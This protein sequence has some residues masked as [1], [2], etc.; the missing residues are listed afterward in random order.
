MNNPAIKHL[1]DLIEDCTNRLREAQNKVCEIHGE[2]SAYTNARNT[3][4]QHLAVNELLT[5]RDISANWKGVLKHISKLDV[6]SIDDI[7][8]FSDKNS[9][10]LQRGAIRSQVHLYNR[11]GILERVGTAQYR[12]TNS[13]K[14]YVETFDAD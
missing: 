2:L 12:L 11:R 8:N 5:G 1:D 10:G 13:G 7:E 3:L 4:Q 14:N 9:L 6:V